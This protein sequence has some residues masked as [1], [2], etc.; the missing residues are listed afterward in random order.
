[1][2]TSVL[3]AGQGRV[4]GLVTIVG[5]LNAKPQCIQNA[6]PGFTSPLQRGQLLDDAD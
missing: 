4:D 1:M 3:Q 2:G 6:A 5:A